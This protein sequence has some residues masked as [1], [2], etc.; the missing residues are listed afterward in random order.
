MFVAMKLFTLLAAVSDPIPGP[1]QAIAALQAATQGGADGARLGH[2]LGRIAPG[3]KADLT[4]IDMKDPTW[5]PLNSA[6]RQL[7]HVEAGR[8]VRHVIVDGRIVVRDRQLTT[9]DETT[10]YEAVKA[11][12]AEF[13]RDFA[14]IARRV[15]KLQPY[16]DRA[17]RQIMNAE[18][19]IERLPFG[20]H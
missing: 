5:S 6:A 4:L 8:G 18:L 15:A 17:H 11:V 16:L 19:D 13:R 1:P 7:V 9:L 14:A 2:K 10:I 3:Y 20:S 12:I